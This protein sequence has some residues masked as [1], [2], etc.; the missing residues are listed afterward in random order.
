M[1]NKEDKK[2]LEKL[3]NQ[4]QQVIFEMESMKN[5]SH[6][7]FLTYHKL[8]KHKKKLNAEI[9]KIKNRSI[10]DIIA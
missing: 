1:L 3:E 4:K 8:K 7:C 9:K 6:I 2:L 10:P 5:D